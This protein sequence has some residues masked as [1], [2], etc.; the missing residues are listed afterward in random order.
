MNERFLSYDPLNGITQTLAYDHE[1]DTTTIRSVG[2]CEASLELNKTMANDDDY[3]KD[4]MKRD[5]WHYASIPAILQMK[6]LVEE[7]IDVYKREH[8]DR[9]WA[10]VNHPDYAYLKTTRKIHIAK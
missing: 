6:W 7:G 2:D 9:V 8:A 3:T 5:L 4:G 1:T 10:K